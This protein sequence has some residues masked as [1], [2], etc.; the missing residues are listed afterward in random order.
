[1]RS[2]RRASPPRGYNVV[3][4]ALVPPSAPTAA[5]LLAQARAV[6][7]ALVI[8]G[9]QAAIVGSFTS[10]ALGSARSYP[11]AERGD[12]SAGAGGG[13]DDFAMCAA[14]AESGRSHPTLPRR[15]SRSTRTGSHIVSLLSR[16]MPI[17]WRRSTQPPRSRPCRP[18]PG[19]DYS[20]RIAIATYSSGLW[21]NRQ[22]SQDCSNN[23][24]KEGLRNTN[25]R[26]FPAH[27]AGD[28]R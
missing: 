27:D 3:S 18:L 1:M 5:Q 28:V 2:G 23:N 22:L 15:S 9:C 7:I 17:C 26:R 14:A 21:E 24:V 25:S 6:Q 8:E 12:R 16:N 4:G 10:S 13:G 19:A 20:S 11:S